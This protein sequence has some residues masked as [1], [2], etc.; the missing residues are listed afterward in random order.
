M[1]LASPYTVSTRLHFTADA[2]HLRKIV[3]IQLHV[4]IAGDERMKR[5][6]TEAEYERRTTLLEQVLAGLCNDMKVFRK[7]ADVLRRMKVTGRQNG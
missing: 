6:G 2:T 3:H 4:H 5:N 7:W 1:L